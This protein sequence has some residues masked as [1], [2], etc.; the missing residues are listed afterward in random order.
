MSYYVSII[1]KTVKLASD[2]SGEHPDTNVEDSPAAMVRN[3]LAAARYNRRRNA[4][5]SWFK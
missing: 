3:T 1:G 5:G 4:V 2:T